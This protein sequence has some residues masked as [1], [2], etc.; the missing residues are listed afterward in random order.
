[1]ARLRL[2]VLILSGIALIVL[3]LP[4]VSN[5]TAWPIALG[6][7]APIAITVGVIAATIVSRFSTQ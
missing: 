1:M 3:V 2:P 7:V 4:Y 5:A 6:V